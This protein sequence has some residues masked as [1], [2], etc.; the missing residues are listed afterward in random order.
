MNRL[1][2]YLI[3]HY[4]EGVCSGP[5]LGL[6]VD[7]IVLIYGS[8]AEDDSIEGS[9]ETDLD[10]HVSLATHDLEAGDVGHV[11][12]SLHIP[13]IEVILGRGEGQ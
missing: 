9:V 4:V 1:E 12:R 8:F 7:T 6:D 13:E 10:L 3:I 5:C 2:S 11:W